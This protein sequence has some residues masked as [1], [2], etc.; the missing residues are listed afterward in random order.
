LSELGDVLRIVSLID[1][2][3]KVRNDSKVAGWAETICEAV[4][5][6]LAA[7]ISDRLSSKCPSLDAVDLTLSSSSVKSD[8][9]HGRRRAYEHALRALEA[10]FDSVGVYME[11]DYEMAKDS[12]KIEY[13]DVAFDGDE[14][15][16][17]KIGIQ[18]A[19]S[20]KGHLSM[21]VME[22]M[23]SCGLVANSEVFY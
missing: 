16:K 3:D 2:V 21:P 22:A 15:I 4:S 9:L 5:V 23:A 6:P 8:G 12:L 14:G 19:E 17:R 13:S 20:L 11:S 1:K 7:T 18:L 10:E